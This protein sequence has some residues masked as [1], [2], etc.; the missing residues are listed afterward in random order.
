MSKMTW[1]GYG[2]DILGEFEQFWR[3]G[4]FLDVTLICDDSTL[5]AHK[6][7]LAASSH[8]FERILCESDCKHPV[9]S[10]NGF[11]G[12]QVAACLDFIYKGVVHLP[13]DQVIDVVAIAQ[14]LEVRFQI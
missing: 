6:I 14:E 7:V 4:D 1:D 10:L 12:W 9:I 2:Q 3:L 11:Q 8:Y 5:R 13:I